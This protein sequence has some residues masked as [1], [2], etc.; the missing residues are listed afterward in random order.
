VTA[1][2]RVDRAGPATGASVVAA[3]PAIGAWGPDAEADLD[4]LPDA[5]L[6][7]GA[8]QRISGANAA[9]VALLGYAPSELVGASCVGLLDAR[10]GDGSSVWAQG[11][12]RASRL[13]GV[14]RLAEQVV[15]LR[16]RDGRSISVTVT[17]TYRRDAAGA[18][19]G[20][21][22][23]LR[24]V[25]HRVE[26]VRALEMVAM[27]SHELRSPLTSIKGYTSLLLERWDGLADDDKVMMLGQVGRDADRVTRLI[28]ELLDIGRLESGRL[29][30]RRRLVDLPVLTRSVLDKVRLEYPGME[31]RV[32]WSDPFPAVYADPDKVEQVLT[33]LLE[34][35]CKYASRRGLVVSGTVQPPPTAAGGPASSEPG[36]PP[37]GVRSPAPAERE[38][39]VVVSD[40]GAGIAADDL[41][42]VFTRFF[43]RSE[44]RPDGSGLGLWI[45]RG[46]VEA[47]GGRLTA[48]SIPGEGSAFR[49]T[50]PLVDLD[51]TLVPSPRPA[52][53]PPTA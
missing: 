26:S 14:R 31:A 3:G 12:D 5:V 27:V 11:W 46:L 38:V 48:S 7:L 16:P 36:S 24:P 9:A 37:P 21:V 20:L 49:F 32:E 52:S 10:H 29:V 40:R 47:H 30:L 42:Q 45:S 4:L 2:P 41:P 35:A 53:A 33:N 43:R 50:L 8:D 28:G 23:C 25:R 19:A 34:N 18:P 1:P 39:V 15:I 13:P 51:E 6:V 22:L 44:G 17:G